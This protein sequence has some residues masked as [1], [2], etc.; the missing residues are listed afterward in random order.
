VLGVL[1]SSG[2]PSSAD[3]RKAQRLNCVNNLK[4][5]DISFRLWIG[6]QGDK[7]PTQVSTKYGGVMELAA[8]G[9]VAAVFQVMSNEL[10]TP[11]VLFCPADI[12][13]QFAPNFTS[14]TIS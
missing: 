9:N 5:I 2:V 4:Q 1:I 6:D 12:D 3:R 7:Y 8:T 14:N 10:S 11:K 13:H